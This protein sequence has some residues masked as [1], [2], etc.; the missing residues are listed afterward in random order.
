MRS[1]TFRAVHRRS[2][3]VIGPSLYEHTIVAADDDAAIEQA[4]MLDLDLAETGANAMYLAASDGRAV[5]SL[6]IAGSTNAD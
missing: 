5:W 3:G 4:R 2:D 1:Y 6:H